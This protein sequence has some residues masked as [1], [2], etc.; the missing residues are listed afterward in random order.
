MKDKQITTNEWV[1]VS[2]NQNSL[3]VGERTCIQGGI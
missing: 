3:T 2:D 1:S